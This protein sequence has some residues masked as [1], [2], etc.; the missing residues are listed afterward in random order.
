MDTFGLV[1]KGPIQWDEWGGFSMILNSPF[2]TPKVRAER[3]GLA[4][5]ARFAARISVCH[6]RAHHRVSECPEIGPFT[7]AVDK[8]VNRF[9]WCTEIILCGGRQD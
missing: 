2:R 7:A 4:S 6:Y 3:L 1:L 8:L 5:K 9:D